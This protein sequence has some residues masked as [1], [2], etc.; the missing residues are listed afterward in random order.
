[1]QQLYVNQQFP[2]DWVR[3]FTHLAN[4]FFE[5][6]K[7]VS[8]LVDD[9]TIDIRF[10]E[11]TESPSVTAELRWLGKQYEAQFTEEI[12]ATEAREI[13]RQRKRMY[14]HV[15]LEVLEQATGMEQEWGILTGIRPTKLYHMY[16]Q[17]G[18]SVNEAKRLL[19]Q[20]HRVS[21]RKSELIAQIAG[22]QLN[23]LPDL[24]TLKQEVS[25]YIGIPF[26]PTKCAYCT[27]PAYAI[28]RK[29]GRV[30]SFL[31][32]LHEEMR[33]I[34]SWLKEHDIRITTIYFGGGTPTSIEADE[35]DALYQAM[36]DSF[37]YMEHVREVTVEAGRPDTITVPKLEVLKKWGID[38]ISVNPQSYT[39]ET[40]KAIGRHHSVQ[41]TIDK[42]WLSREQGMRNINM[43]LIIG[44]PNEGLAEFEHSLAETEKM[45]P[46]SL[47]IHTLSF[48]RASEMTRNKDKYQVAD[49]KTVSQ[50]MTRGEEWSKA[51]GYIPYYLY[52][53][54]NILGNLEN[55]G[56][57]KPGEESLYNILIMEEAQ[58]IIGLGCGAS[59]KF[60]DPA[61]GK[62]TQFHNPKEP[63]AY[64]LG[65]EESID[66]KI[67]YLDEV[68]HSTESI[69]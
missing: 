68:F 19:Q 62:L 30:E 8:E 2:Q 22:I 67:A 43:D 37:P 9:E 7:I 57:A 64:I 23:A 65:F 18:F 52:R 24:Y 33:A 47:T 38:R 61:T 36:V 60:M 21:V 13:I 4:L 59:S 15:L 48:K 32:G 44:L 51:N 56:Y 63:A 6:S 35:M 28:H 50:M 34:G 31:D 55:V 45:Q 40:L 17:D 25:I 1:M 53:Q 66:R 69:K 20:R 42:Y 14:S 29:N 3:M 11:D 58:T 5:Q 46:E 12:L 49:R 16:R 27:F 41:E 10:T 39:D 26:C 54:K